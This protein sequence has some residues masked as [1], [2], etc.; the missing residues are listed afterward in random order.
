MLFPLKTRRLKQANAAVPAEDG[1][2]ISGGANLFGLPETL[3]GAFEEGQQSVGRLARDE[4]RFGSALV[5]DASVVEAFVRVGEFQKD[6]FR[7]AV[8]VVAA[9]AELVS[10]G[11][12]EHAEGELLFWLSGENVAADRF[13]FFWLVEIAVEFGFGEGFGDPRVGDGFEFVVHDGLQK[14]PI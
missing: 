13:R 10:D 3:Q 11:K 14:E 7:V 1:V 9:A 2:V 8:A 12:A 4:L 6:F 5:A